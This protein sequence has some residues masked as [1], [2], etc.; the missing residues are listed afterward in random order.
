MNKQRKTSH[1][2]NVFQYDADGHVVLPASLTLTVPPAGNDNSAKVTTTAW[3]RTYVSGL[4]YQGAI[5]LTVTGTS[6]AA[7][8]VGNTL[9]IPT[10]TLAGLGGQAALS[11]TGFVKISGT[12]ISYDNSTY[13]TETYVGTA[14]SN[15]VD[16]SPATLDTLNELAAALGDDPNFATTVATSIGTKQAQL[17]GTGFVKVSGTTVSYDN[18]TY[19]TTATGSSTYVPYIGATT[20]VNLGAFDLTVNELTIGKGLSALSNN[21]ALGY[22]S[23]YHTTTGNFNTSV[24]YQSGHNIT[25]GQYN[26]TLGQSAMFTNNTGSQNTA[27]GVNSLLNNTSGSSN[28]AVG[29]DAMQHNT[30]GNSNTALGYN[31]GSHLTNGITPNETTST[32]VYLGRDTKASASGNANETVIGYNAIGNGSNTVTIGNSSVTANYLKGS[33]NAG[34]FVKT[35]GTSS[36]FLKADGSVDSN[37]YLTTSS[38]S[39]SYVPYTGASTDLVL[40]ANNF[41]AKR[42][43]V[44]KS[45]DGYS[46]F[47]SNYLFLQTGSSTTNVGT[48]GISLF[49]K[50]NTRALVINY[51]I[52]GTN[53]SATL[54]AALLTA[55]R[56][57]EFPNASGTLALTSGIPTNNNT[58]T[59]GAGYVNT[60][61]SPTTS[62]IPKFTGATTIANSL[63]YDTGSVILIGA[64][65]ASDNQSKLELI[66]SGTVG[67]KIKSSGVNGNNTFLSIESSK[68]WRFLTNRGDLISGNQGD[69]I[70][71]NNTDGINHIILNQSGATTFYGALSGTSATFSSSVGATSFNLGNGQFLRLTRNSG[72]LQY[73]AFGIVAGTDNTRIISTGDFDIVN[74]SLTSQFKIASTGAATF[75]VPRTN[76]TNA[77]SIILSDNLTG[78]STPGYGTRIV[79]YSNGNSVQS[80]IGFENGGTGTNNESQLSFYT[81]NVAGSLTRQLLITSTGVANFSNRIEIISNGGTNPVLAI[82]QTNAATQGYD[83]ETEDVSV[84]RLDLYGVTSGGRVQMMTWIKANG[85]VGIGAI[86]PKTKLQ[87]T[88]VSNAEV[89]VLGTATGV[90]IFTSANTNYG[91]QFNSTSDGSFHIQSQRFDA[92]ATAYNLILNYAG[93]NIGIGGN[94]APGCSLDIGSRTDAIAIPKGTTAQR[95]GSPSSGMGRFNTEISKTEFYN[96]T[97][98][99]AIGGAGDGSTSSSAAS[100]A[101]AIKAAVGNPTSGVYWLQIPNV[102][103]GNAFQCYCDFTM[104]GGI[105]YAIIVNQYFTGP[106]TGPSHAN[107]ASSTIGTAGYDTEYIISPSAMLANYGVTKLAVFARVGGSSSGGIANATYTNWVAFSGPTS[108]QY[109]TIFTQGFGSTQFTGSFVSADGNTGTAYFPN[110]HGN[111]GGVTQ[112]TTNGGTVNDYLLYE[113]NANGGSDPNHFWMVLNGRSGDTYWAGNTRYG[114][115]SGNVMYNRWGGVALY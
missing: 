11:G 71:R 28:V 34:S 53:Y 81:Q 75:S 99:V 67:L 92:S 39:T 58:L 40:G 37:T 73:D 103:G 31:A 115:S 77:T 22:R 112:I 20:A 102:N 62:Y 41:S 101:K 94:T 44:L 2:L 7:T 17:N 95:P 80:V 43:S 1:I 104:N 57:F 18:S 105:G 52:G 96:G 108:T 82:R 68:E 33:V 109:N 88:P 29:L 21:T 42:V 83:F 9:N 110:S 38:A 76:G 19:L 72:A 61:G 78:V 55:S 6:G 114:S 74:G 113:Y 111:T 14:I 45:S 69:L 85:R 49:S 106:E 48:D 66:S 98:W 24:G 3:V 16:S 100:S 27:I 107:F 89:P 50:P 84:G 54:D 23:L 26:T 90:A 59:N 70:I 25:T 46:G 35:G 51:D 56:T 97:V 60:S 32:S 63:I 13:A 30:T 10:Y 15:L 12:T 79:G 64:T 87:V 5:T 86:A 93:G 47:T 36:Q 8:L 65:T 91:L 4:S